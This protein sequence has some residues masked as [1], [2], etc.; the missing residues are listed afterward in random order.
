MIDRPT[1]QLGSF[2]VGEVP[3][4]LEY[5][6]L[7]VSGDP[8]DLTGFTN[9]GFNW[10]HL[11]RGQ[12]TGA[13]S[14]SAIVTDAVNGIATYAWDGDEFAEPGTHAGQF[15]VN[16]GTTQYASVVIIWQVCLPVG[17]PPTV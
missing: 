6:F 2:V 14:E 16:D 17:V 8:V 5:Q 1:V 9:V 4:P 11:V 15:W 7:D 12:V 3:L 10:G 13:V